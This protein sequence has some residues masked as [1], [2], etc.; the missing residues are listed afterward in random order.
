MSFSTSFFSHN[1]QAIW[2]YYTTAG[3]FRVRT[4][5]RNYPLLNFVFCSDI[6]AKTTT[7]N[8]LL[9]RKYNTLI[10]TYFVNR[11]WLMGFFLSLFLLLICMVFE[12][13]YVWQFIIIPQETP[14]H[15]TFSSNYS[16]LK[17]KF[18]LY[19]LHNFP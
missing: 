11:T 7:E 8:V 13:K 1:S 18:L 3:E 19:I 17:K 6:G 5:Y 14:L 12:R 9:R 4:S 15:W 2:Y 10:C 16:F